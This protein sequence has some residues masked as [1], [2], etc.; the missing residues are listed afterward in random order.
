MLRTIEADLRANVD[1]NRTS[2]IRYWARLLGKALVTPQVQVVIL[3][4]LGHALMGTPLRP[5]A[6][7]LR[8]LGQVWSGAEIHPAAQL[9]PGFV[10]VH[11][12]GVTIGAHV[13]TGRDCRVAQGVSI[14]VARD[15]GRGLD[16]ATK[17]ASVL[18]EHVTI[19][20][21]SLVIGPVQVGDGAVIGGHTVVTRDVPPN[22]IVAGSPAK[23][24]RRLLP[25]DEDPTR[26]ITARDEE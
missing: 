13:R 19:G 10:L 14:G 22:C 24:L 21:L 15:A 7:L 16:D 12:S 4:R 18:G 26:T 5:L 6:Y 2:G 11:S 9:G 1:R 20:P 17:G 25:F 8:A 3:Y 23:V